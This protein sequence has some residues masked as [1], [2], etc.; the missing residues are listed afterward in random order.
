MALKLTTRM[1]YGNACA[2]KI[3]PNG[4]E[5]EVQFSPSPCGAAE[6]LWFHFRLFESTPESP[7]GTRIKL[8]MNHADTVSGIDDP[9]ALVPV[10]HKEGQAW[11][12]MKHGV[13]EREPDGQRRV[14]WN[15][16]YPEPAVEVALCYP[17]GMP[18]IKNLVSKAK[19][20]WK[21]DSVGI[22]GEGR[23]IVRLSNLYQVKSDHHPGLYVVARRHA[24]ETPGS[25]VLDGLLRH[26]S[27]SGKTPLLVWAFP[28]ADIDGV[29]CGHY[30]TSAGDSCRPELRILDADIQRWKER[31]R[32]LLLLDLSASA[33]STKDGVHCCLPAEGETDPELRKETERWA[34]MFKTA[35]TPAFASGDFM[36]EPPEPSL[37]SRHG[38]CSLSLHI[39]Y[40]QIGSTELTPKDYRQ[41]GKRL[42]DAVVRR[43]GKS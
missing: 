5:V 10:Y 15:L 9:S 6:R 11:S 21:L 23:E 41:F 37:F 14:I 17:Y 2:T 42:A 29:L 22:S 4:D 36:R 12:R 38:I 19:G 31:C 25:W 1:P 16:R 7:Q 3:H 30:R 27:V 33:I 40:S 20:Y 8:V 24:G 32:P 13:I 28:L 34:N 35:L 43:Q 26:L 39:P 18:E